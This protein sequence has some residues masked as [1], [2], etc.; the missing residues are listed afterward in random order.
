[1]RY[2]AFPYQ[3]RPCPS[4]SDL[5]PS[6]LVYSLDGAARGVN[7]T[8]HECAL[9]GTAVNRVVGYD[10]ANPNGNNFLFVEPVK[11]SAQIKDVC[12]AAESV[13]YGV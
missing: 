2:N 3:R 5:V 7:F 11:S 10:I 1:M 6:T 12:K 4:C 13:R 9:C 8:V